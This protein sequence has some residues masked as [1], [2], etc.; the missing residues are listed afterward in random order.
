MIKTLKISNG[1]TAAIG[2]IQ[3]QS[4]S[5]DIST[6]VK[7]QLNT[8]V[9]LVNVPVV[10]N[11]LTNGVLKMTKEMSVTSL[12]T[13]MLTDPKFI[14]PPF[15]NSK[16]SVNRSFQVDSSL[17]RK[18]NSST[19]RTTSRTFSPYEQLT[20]ISGDR[21]E[22]IMLTN[23]SPLFNDVH[24]S[25]HSFVGMMMNNGID[26]RMTDAGLYVDTQL[27]SGL[28]RHENNIALLNGLQ[29]KYVNVHQNFIIRRNQFEK[30]IEELQS[31][32]NFLFDTMK[33][34]ENLKTQL[35][36]RNEIYIVNPY[37]AAST[38][39]SNYMKIRTM[40]STLVT[41]DL[42]LKKHL[43]TTYSITDIFTRL[44]YDTAN[45]KHKFLSSKI[46][47]QLLCE[48][49]SI[50]THHSRELINA[51]S[52]RRKNDDEN[53]TILKDEEGF[54]ELKQTLNNV[55]IIRELVAT[56]PQQIKN[57]VSSLNQVFRTM[58]SA[59]NLPTPEINVVAL[60]NLISK[61]F[62]Y[63]YGLSSADVK[64]SL[65]ENFKYDVST[66]NEDVFDAIIG[67]AGNN[68]LEFPAQQTNSLI[69]LAQQQPA[70][71]VA[72][73]T[74]EPGYVQ[75]TSNVMTPGSSFYIDD[76]YKLKDA[77][78]N[79]ARIDELSNKF[80]KTYQSF[81][82]IMNGLNLMGSKTYDPFDTSKTE[83]STILSSP[84]DFLNDII[85]QIVD[86]T[87]GATNSN[88]D[89]DLLTTVYAF[90][91]THNR[92]KSA[93]FLYTLA[94]LNR[95]LFKT[96]S[97][98]TLLGKQEENSELSDSLVNEI[99]Y[100]LESQV[101]TYS[102]IDSRSDLVISKDA[103]R[104]SI[105]A[106]SSIT[107]LVETIMQQVQSSFN[108]GN[109]AIVNN[110]T[111]FNGYTDSV[112]MMSVFDL[113]L[114]IISL[115][116][117]KS[118]V[119]SLTNV[120]QTT[121]GTLVYNI[122][123]TQINKR[124]IVSDLT[125]RIKKE[126]AL[127]QGL[128]YTITNSIS[129]FS[130]SMKDTSSYLNEQATLNKLKTLSQIVSDNNVLQ[131]LFN[132]QQISLL[133]NTVIDISDVMLRQGSAP[134]NGDIDNDNDFDS[135]DEFKVLDDSIISP[136]TRKVLYGFFGSKEFATA[137]G[138][139]KKIITIGVPLGFTKKLKNQA[140]INSL[141]SGVFKKQ[142]D[143][144][145]I[146]VYKVDL[147]NSDVIF[148]PQKFLF[149]MSRFPVRNDR[150]YLQLPENPSLN[151]VVNSIP[152]RDFAQG[153]NS[154]DPTYWPVDLKTVLS[155]KKL[156]FESSDYSF[157][158]NN[159]RSSLIKNHITSHM[160]E[161]YI[162]LLTG[163]SVA[164]HHFDLIDM[165]KPVDDGFIKLVIEHHVDNVLSL[166]NNT[167]KLT[168]QKE[169]ETIGGLLFA[170]TSI[171]KSGF[172]TSTS[173]K[174]EQP[175]LSNTTGV[176][177]GS[178]TRNE[179]KKNTSNKSVTSLNADAITSKNV[180]RVLE[181][182]RIAGNMS[183]MITPMTNPLIVSTKVLMP[184]QFDRVFNIIIDPDD[185]EINYE[186][187]V[188]TDDGKRVLEQLLKSGD[189]IEDKVVTETVK[190]QENISTFK[191]RSRDK[192]Q[193]DLSFEKYFITFETYDESTGVL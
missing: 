158:T 33:K 38:F 99:L 186:E 118:I 54:F 31:M 160:S 112:I 105:K 6:S 91:A 63:S 180:P 170:T 16:G 72:V 100:S 107:K 76:I 163:T 36:L 104:S 96:V 119:S 159:E 59:V 46:W 73:L 2:N 132:E 53:K 174:V 106:S 75:T 66:T 102:S 40:S 88:I 151:D 43:P 37:E 56:P 3:A 22:I 55:P 81:N 42:I 111:R 108:A 148:K 87:T 5:S 139:N 11:S 113:I 171:R 116:T 50:L 60:V 181:G 185:F 29:T 142:N 92:V 30:N 13:S 47:I 149:E 184:K 89:S 130:T 17:F 20:G 188:R 58:Y 144:I 127:I 34:I 12:A 182:F 154:T 150:H 67:L 41:N 65:S 147:I 179:T 24:N 90:G 109:R 15:Q 137:K 44:G 189:I 175:K 101:P 23:F 94:K 166:F 70:T 138:N 164:E 35:D 161:M 27:Q 129:K 122:Q 117:N 49:K 131:L 126:L 133:S 7:Q 74:F 83:Y 57:T 110:K 191:L 86:L 48:L 121:P 136:K 187:T 95:T 165:P 71:N 9:H 10:T 82:V 155:G 193:G 190:K 14:L 68:V 141:T 32:S 135:D 84:I 62:S 98:G 168:Q 21:P 192:N 39:Q 1:L 45:V 146:V 120:S 153:V 173:S 78:F 125:S 97:D 152:T 52:T 140:I 183:K 134:D 176:G 145:N 178:N 69:N 157:L 167:T 177:G 172:M 28:L 103:I 79:T 169:T 61:E 143:V 4:V 115:C 124:T 18:A 51:S 26:I 8:P 77:R 25:E 114:K 156:S 128:L 93:L 85:R 19:F 80:D 64:Q 162:K 123:Q